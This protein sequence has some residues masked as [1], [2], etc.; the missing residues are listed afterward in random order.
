MN[1]ADMNWNMENKNTDEIGGVPEGRMSE[2]NGF[3]PSTLCDLVSWYN[4]HCSMLRH[5]GKLEI[6]QG[7]VQMAC[8]CSR[9]SLSGASEGNTW[10]A[11][12]SWGRESNHWWQLL[13]LV[14]S[15]WADSG[16]TS[17]NW[18]D[19]QTGHAEQ[20]GD[21]RGQK[22]LSKSKFW[23][24]HPFHPECFQWAWIRLTFRKIQIFTF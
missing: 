18:Q 3:R 15:S 2:C 12:R 16:A 24:P 10:L 8:V 17:W 5:S 7:G 13:D 11:V 9:M 21:P 1:K 20:I 19:L 4:D 23:L 14:Q 6:R 22:K